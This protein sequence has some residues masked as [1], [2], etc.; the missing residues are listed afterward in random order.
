MSDI[1]DQINDVH[2]EVGSR[3]VGE[4][5][6]EARTVLLRR[7]YDAAVE[8]VWDACTTKERISRWFLP[9]SGDLKPGGH[10]QLEGN[11]GGEILKCEPPRLLKVSWVMGES[12]GLSEVEVRLTPGGEGET[13]LELEHVAVVPPEFWDQFGPGA[14]GVGWD[15]GLLGL[16]LHL[17]GESVGDP[18]EWEATD[19][20]REFMTRSSEA[21]GTAY[22]TSGAPADVAAAAVAGTTAFYAPPR[23]DDAG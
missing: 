5:E 9:V 16:G 14:V 20:A 1:V 3:R 21:W 23:E 12:P 6:E 13:V 19:E 2:R 11:A 17:R 8:D 4:P 15:M 10:Y 22:E 7:T 18:S